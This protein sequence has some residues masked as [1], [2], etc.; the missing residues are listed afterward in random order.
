MGEP[1]VYIIRVYRRDAIGI[2]G[3][4]EAVAT[5]MQSRFHTAEV[6]W[7][8]L[9]DLPSSRRNLPTMDSDQEDER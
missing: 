4:V 8:A 2:A 5:G 3:V 1:E 7:R 9:H 6:L